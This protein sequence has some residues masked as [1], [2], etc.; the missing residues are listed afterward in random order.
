[1]T[2]RNPF[3]N[4]HHNNLGSNTLTVQPQGGG[5]KKSGFPK[6]VGRDTWTSQAIKERGSFTLSFW[7][8]TKNPGTRFSRPLGS[9]GPS[10]NTYYHI[11]NTGFH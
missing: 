2:R 6:I 10:I 4:T 1:M 11:P 9:V 7:M 5:N 8:N 3:N